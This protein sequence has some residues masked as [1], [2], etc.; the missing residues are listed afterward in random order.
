M[1]EFER[2][3]GWMIDEEVMEIATGDRGVI[4]ESATM[5]AEDAVWIE[6]TTGNY[7]GERLW[8]YVHQV[9]FVNVSDE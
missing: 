2:F 5:V 9:R 7:K 6:W 8:L 1:K 3:E 4:V